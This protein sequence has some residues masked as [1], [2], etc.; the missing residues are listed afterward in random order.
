MDNRVLKEISKALEDTMHM[1]VE[2][3]ARLMLLCELLIEKGYLKDEEVMK[4]LSQSEID[5]ILS[6]SED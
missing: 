6:E 1:N 5:K 4:K 2:T 3:V